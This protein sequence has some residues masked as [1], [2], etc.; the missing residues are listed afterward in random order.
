M[1]S[2]SQTEEHAMPDTSKK[3]ALE[4]IDKSIAEREQLP[5]RGKLPPA[6]LPWKGWV[7]TA[8]K[9]V[10]QIFPPP[11]EHVDE[12]EPLLTKILDKHWAEECLSVSLEAVSL[13]RSFRSEIEDRWDDEG[14]VANHSKRTPEAV[15]RTKAEEAL[16][17]DIFIVHGHDEE[18]KQTVARF[19]GQLG[20]EAIILHERPN[21]GR[22]LIE[23]FESESLVDFAIVVLTP[24]DM[25]YPAKDSDKVEP[26]ARQNVIFELGFFIGAL[27]RKYVCALIKGDV[28]KPSDYD[29]I[30][31]I[32]MDPKGAWKQDLAREMKH[33]GVDVDMNKMI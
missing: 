7:R 13:L 19:V 6:L 17:K 21:L 8:Q 26:R 16:S 31:Y 23:K 29:G 9:R 14:P 20:L 3:K 5:Q 30:V 32:E 15:A 33:A 28:K 12:I 10:G 25:G 27:K 22:T 4:L 24:D 11:S 2:E 18:A 1:S